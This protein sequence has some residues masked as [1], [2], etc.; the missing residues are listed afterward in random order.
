M[1]SFLTITSA[2]SSTQEPSVPKDLDGGSGNG[3]ACVVAQSAPETVPTEFDGGSGNGG[4]CVI[5]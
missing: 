4:A 5:A 3:G 1:D 2:S